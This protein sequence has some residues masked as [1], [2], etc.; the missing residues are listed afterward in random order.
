MLLLSGCGADLFNVNWRADPDTAL[1]YSMARPELNL[2]SAY[3]LVR[4]NALRVEA[5]NSAGRWDF[6]LDT[7]D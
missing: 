5:P 3:D 1:V 6:A 2:P 4:R 7:Q